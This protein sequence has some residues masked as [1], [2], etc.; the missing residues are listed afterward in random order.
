MRSVRHS[1]Y[2]GGGLNHDDERNTLDFSNKMRVSKKTMPVYLLHPRAYPVSKD[3]DTGL[4]TYSVK[5]IAGR[6][7][8]G[9]NYLVPIPQAEIEKDPPLTQNPGY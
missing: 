2:D 9:K 7:F 8:Y 6:N 4:K 1:S 3:P 5:I